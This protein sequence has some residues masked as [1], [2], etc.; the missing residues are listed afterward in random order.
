MEIFS[1]IRFAKV[2]ENR[3][4]RTHLLEKLLR[5]AAFL[6]IYIAKCTFFD[7]YCKIFIFANATKRA[8][9]FSTGGFR[10]ILIAQITLGF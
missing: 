8:V 5:T 4:G 10:N 7:V 6:G 3:I 1:D 2:K 9:D